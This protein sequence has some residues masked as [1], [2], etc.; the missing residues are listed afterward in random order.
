MPESSGAS[1]DGNGVD[2]DT[3]P[4]AAQC[5]CDQTTS[6]VHQLCEAVPK[7]TPTVNATVQALVAM[8]KTSIEP[9]VNWPKR[10]I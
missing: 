5:L 3:D 8:R 1:H 4:D 7:L 9:K 10:E 6:L 2:S